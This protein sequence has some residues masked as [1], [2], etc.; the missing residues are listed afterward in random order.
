[1]PAL[2]MAASTTRRCCCRSL[3]HFNSSNTTQIPQVPGIYCITGVRVRRIRSRILYMFYFRI[4]TWQQNCWW[5]YTAASSAAV[6]EQ[7]NSSNTTE[8]PPHASLTWYIRLTKKRPLGVR[9]QHQQSKDPKQTNPPHARIL[10]SLT[11]TRSPLQHDRY[12]RTNRLPTN[13][14][15]ALPSSAQGP[16]TAYH[17]TQKP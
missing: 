5:Q 8:V 2:P 9:Y 1:M 3:G 16:Y 17:I 11:H 15:N 12:A 14:T 13:K 4:C 7:F 6:E 10:A